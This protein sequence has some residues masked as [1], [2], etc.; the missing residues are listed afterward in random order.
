MAKNFEHII[1]KNSS[2][3]VDGSPKLPT[4]SQLEY[5]EIAVNYANGQETISLKNSN[6]EIVTFS[7]DKKF[8]ETEHAISLS[9]ND[10]NE[11]INNNM[12]K[13]NGIDTKFD[14]VNDNIDSLE[15]KLSN[16]QRVTAAALNELNSR[17][18]EVSASDNGKILMVVNGEWALVTP[19]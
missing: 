1:H 8:E 9:L 7:S 10:L 4:S 11:R 12:T 15:A 16:A 3:V 13:L 5:G 18:P 19:S 14:N 6:N 17:L 2:V